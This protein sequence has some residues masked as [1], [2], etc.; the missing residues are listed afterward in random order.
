[1]IGDEAVLA[2]YVLEICFMRQPRAGMRTRILTRRLCLLGE[3]CNMEHTS[4]RSILGFTATSVYK[5]RMVVIYNA[6]RMIAMFTTRRIAPSV[7]LPLPFRDALRS[8]S[9]NRGYTN[10]VHTQHMHRILY[11]KSCRWNKQSDSAYA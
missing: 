4:A 5:V 1:M 11:T 3:L 10:I 2:Y 8:P 9:S 7:P 6:I